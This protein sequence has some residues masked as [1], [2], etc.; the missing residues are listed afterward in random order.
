MKISSIRRVA[1]ELKREINS[2]FI[3]LGL[4]QTYLEKKSRDPVVRAHAAVALFAANRMS[5]LRLGKSVVRDCIN[6]DKQIDPEAVAVY[7]NCFA[8]FPL[9]ELE[10]DQ[11]KTSIEVEVVERDD[12]VFAVQ[13]T[14]LRKQL[15]IHSSKFPI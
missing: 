4:G 12:V 7:R 10:A 3:L 1:R 14:L 2:T 11:L 9:S 13:V 8:R 5:L 15:I 6:K